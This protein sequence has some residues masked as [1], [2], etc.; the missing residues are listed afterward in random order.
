MEKRGIE[1]TVGI[2]ILMGLVIM[3]SLIIIFG[4]S[5]SQAN[6]KSTI[7]VSFPNANGL[8][9]DSKALMSGVRIGKVI[10]DPGIS[11]SGDSALIKIGLF[12]GF[13]IREGSTFFIREAGLLGDRYVDIIPN[14]D[15]KASLLK[16][17]ANIQGSRTAGIGDL[18]QD[19]K[20]V[21]DQTQVAIAKI[22]LIL[23]K[24]DENVL[25][26][27]TQIEFKS[28]IKRL[29]SVLGHI[30][31]LVAQAEKGEGIL[32]KILNDKTMADDLRA[33]IYNIRQRG[34]LFYKDVAA[35]EAKE[36]AP[37]SKPKSTR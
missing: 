17:G 22:N 4:R 19:A 33:F 1:T 29:N 37:T 2:F 11:E 13:V 8:L 28:A 18:T 26:P 23:N 32:A 7:I 20:P 27:E 15:L 14:T 30:D 21:L 3:S 25:T 10:D 36:Q 6:I 31:S 5:A 12:E 34:V 16:S 24:I 9:K 35:G